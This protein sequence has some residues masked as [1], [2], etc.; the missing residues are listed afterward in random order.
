[1]VKICVIFNEIHELIACLLLICVVIHPH[2]CIYL[3]LTTESN[4]RI[5]GRCAIIAISQQESGTEQSNSYCQFLHTDMH[6]MQCIDTLFSCFLTAQCWLQ[7]DTGSEL[8][9]SL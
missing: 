5:V 7:M 4:V 6:S 3:N 8:C 9:L 1:M 2:S